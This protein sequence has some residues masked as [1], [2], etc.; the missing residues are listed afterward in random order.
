M[1]VVRADSVGAVA[2][3]GEAELVG[4]GVA[5]LGLLCAGFVR[6]SPRRAE[7]ALEGALV[8][9]RDPVPAS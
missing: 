1:S 9:D 4:G 3:Y 2:A 8:S 5:F 6:S 7:G